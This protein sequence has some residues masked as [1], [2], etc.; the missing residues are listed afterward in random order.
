MKKSAPKN[1]KN[2]RIKTGLWAPGDL[3]RIKSSTWS[4]RAQD[5]M[6]VVIEE[7]N[8]TME[9]MFPCAVIYDME[10][11]KMGRFYLYDL[12]LISSRA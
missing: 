9:G 1:K 8:L 3:V 12:E 6:G 4:G 10:Q 11:K 5:R 2:F 7:I